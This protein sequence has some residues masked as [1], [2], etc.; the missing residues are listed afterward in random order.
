MTTSKSQLSARILA[1]ASVLVIAPFARG[2]TA[3]DPAVSNAL[4]QVVS[5]H[6]NS[7][8]SRGMVL[9]I[10]FSDGSVYE[11]ARGT[12]DTGRQQPLRPDHHLGFASITKTFVATAVLQL[13]EDGLLGLDTPVSDVMTPPSQ[14]SGR[15]TIRQLLGHQSGLFNYTDSPNLLPQFVSDTSRVWTPEAVMAAFARSNMFAPGMGAT[16]SNTNYVML[17][18][19]AEQVEV[20][21]LGAHMRERLLDPLHLDTIVYG[22]EETPRGSVPVTWH[23]LDGNGTLDDFS[24]FYASTS[25]RTGRGAAGGMMGTARDMARWARDLYTGSVLSPAMYDAMLDF[26]NLTGQNAT[27]TGYGLGAQ[28]Y[29]FS[30]IEFWGHSGLISGSASLLLYSPELDVSIA[31]V[32]VDT[33]SSPFALAQVL[34]THLASADDSIAP[35]AASGSPYPNP[36]APGGRVTIERNPG[37][38]GMGELTIMD[39]LGRTLY[40]ETIESNGNHW[41]WQLPDGIRP[42]AVL[43]RLDARTGRQ[44]GILSVHP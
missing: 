15:I 41:S 4:D 10:T 20:R 12:S 19:I 6:F 13:V 37:D 33:R 30:G 26:H 11:T 8:G 44:S 39:V 14:V 21:S 7:T 17:E 9:A 3:S 32:D 42:G 29:I 23:D 35:R 40:R 31:M 2:Q 38:S 28:Q 22:P 18:R 27:W 25:L 16:Y 43:Y 36:V 34:T 24:G 5:S 1:L